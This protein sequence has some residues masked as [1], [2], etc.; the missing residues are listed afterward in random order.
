MTQITRT[1]NHV[2]YLK[3]IGIVLVVIGHCTHPIIAKIIYTFHMPLFFLIAGYY[4]KNKSI[5]RFF[6]KK[7]QLD[8]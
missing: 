1:T 7:Q 2:D 8:Y 5:S 4:S 3:A 6:L